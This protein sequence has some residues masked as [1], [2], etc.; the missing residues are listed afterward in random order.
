MKAI[1]G[2]IVALLVLMNVMIAGLLYQGMPA[3]VI[4]STQ[5][6]CI[7]LKT[8][9]AE[10]ARCETPDRGVIQTSMPGTDDSTVNFV[11]NDADNTLRVTIVPPGVFPPPEDD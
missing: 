7:W 4:D 2:T 9:E 5:T 8:V 3:K 6:V 1:G 10:N 11:F